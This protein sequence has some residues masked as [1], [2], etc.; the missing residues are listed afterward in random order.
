LCLMRAS[1]ILTS[2]GGYCFDPADLRTRPQ[3]RSPTWPLWIVPETGLKQRRLPG[4]MPSWN[5]PDGSLGSAPT[6]KSSDFGIYTPTVQR[7]QA[8]GLSPV[9]Q[10][11]IGFVL[12]MTNKSG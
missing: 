2:H 4:V 10:R 5:L 6:W 3:I 11:L 12:V 8:T 7:Q 1:W 9:K